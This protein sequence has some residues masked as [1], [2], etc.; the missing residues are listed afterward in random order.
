MGPART[1]PLPRDPDRLDEALPWY[2]NGTLDEAD[3]AWVEQVLREQADRAG[4]SAEFP[5]ETLIAPGSIRT[6]GRK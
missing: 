1:T 3:R 6:R 2:L 4:D 5:R